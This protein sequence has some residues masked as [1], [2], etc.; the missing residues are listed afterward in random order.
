LNETGLPPKYLELEIT[1]S[2][3]VSSIMDA[4]MLLSNLQ[5][6]GVKVSLDDFGT[7]YSSLNYLTSLP[8]NTLKIDKSFIDNICLNDK[9]SFIAQSIIQLAHRL[10]IKVVAEG[11]EQESQLELL[12]MQHC[13]II[14]G[15][16]FSAPLHPEDLAEVV[17]EM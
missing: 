15:Y 4:T 13:D 17:S 1:E 3:L 12:K 8:I 16:I 5:Q 7:G 6:I 9:D 2:T 14:Q 11:V 10:N